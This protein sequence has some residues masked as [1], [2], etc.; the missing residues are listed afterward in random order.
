L[1]IVYFGQLCLEIT[2]VAHGKGYV[3]T[4]MGKASFWAILLQSWSP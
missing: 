1:A 2:E 3:M 4:K